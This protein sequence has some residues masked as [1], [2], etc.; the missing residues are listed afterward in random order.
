M[1][2][3]ES[4][5]RSI[6]SRSSP[7]SGPSIEA[8]SKRASGTRSAGRQRLQVRAGHQAYELLEGGLRLP[9]E[10]S[11]GLGRVADQVI[12][13]GRA[14]ERRVYDHE[15]LVVPESRLVEGDLA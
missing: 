12:D 6:A 4:S 1:K 8:V 2:R 11:L 15:G 3:P 10:V 5:T 13:L 14:R 9:A 7:R